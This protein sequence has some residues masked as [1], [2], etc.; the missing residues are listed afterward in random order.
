MKLLCSPHL[1]AVLASLSFGACRCEPPGTGKGTPDYVAQPK[2]LSFEAC[3]TLD[4]TGKPVA[5]VFPDEQRFL[6]TNVGKVGGP[7]NFTFSGGEDAF[8]LV[9]GKYPSYLAEG[10]DAGV[11][12][13][14]APKAP[15][16]SNSVLVIDDGNADTAPVEVTLSGAGSS[17]PAQPQLKVSAEPAPDAGR[18]DDCQAGF[19]CQVTWPETIY[20]E[21]STLRI[22]LTNEGC[23]TL[24]ITGLEL[25]K[26]AVGGGEN[27][28]FTLRE[29]AVLPTTETPLNLNI[30]DG[31]QEYF[32][33]VD[34]QPVEDNSGD[35]RYAMLSIKTSDPANPTFD[36]QLQ[37]N[38]LA[39]SLYV[40]PT[41][42]NF[43]D[44][45]NCLG[46]R[47]G[48]TATFRVNNNGNSALLIKNVSLDKGGWSGRFAI[49]QDV[50]GQTIPAYG[51]Q[52]L[53]VTYTD[54]PTFVI[55]RLAIEGETLGVYAGKAI[56]TVSGGVLPDL[57]TEPDNELDFLNPPDDITT[58]P[59]T[60]K[61]GAGK[62]TL[63][64]NRTFVDPNPFF[65]VVSP[66]VNVQ[67]PA[68][69]S[70]T[71]DVQY[72]KPLSGGS[73]IGVL[74]IDT[75]DPRFGPTP[76]KVITLYSNAPLDQIPIAVLNGPSGAVGSINQS[77]VAITSNPKK[78]SLSG[79]LSYDP[80][81]SGGQVIVTQYQFF[82]V[83][84]PPS[85]TGASL[86][87]DGVATGTGVVDLTLD[88]QAL[89]EYRIVLKVFD[90]KGQAS[91][92]LAD[93]KVFTTN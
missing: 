11:T 51:T 56:V 57:I 49:T 77:L 93:F 83:K 73:Q 74:R 75:N 9:D 45:G 69:T 1:V 64:V 23:P 25:Q 32:L 10:A 27:L 71:I 8:G 43:T 21:T 63:I 54:A 89:G 35:T 76:Y 15:G 70:K 48:N 37:G 79:T 60:I 67:I 59:V 88:N 55:D 72:K 62:G 85:A 18:F 5:E 41:F 34:F 58:K 50:K 22:K 53:V 17:L 29:P 12:V 13:K 47:T 91:Q 86:Q 81:P 78:L 16:L 68:G 4:S 30:V 61:A 65:S 19:G 20:G 7:V 82:L 26:L 46:A 3:P 40:T 84:K 31:T 6:L 66:L 87:N 2:A 36:L 92:N 14:F 33:V 38:G 28:A 42:C 90:D 80:Q 39:P 52:N 44:T 24:K